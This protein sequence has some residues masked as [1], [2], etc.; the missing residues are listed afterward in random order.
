[1][2]YHIT[3]RYE[4]LFHGV[5]CQQKLHQ[6]LLSKTSKNGNHQVLVLLATSD[7]ESNRLPSTKLVN[8]I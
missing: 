3:L 1:M 7:L 5:Q 6:K 8:R 2:Y 4:V